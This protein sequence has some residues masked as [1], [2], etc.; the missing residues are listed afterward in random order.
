MFR[1]NV[2]LSLILVTLTVT[3]VDAVSIN[4]RTG[5]ATLSFSTKINGLGDLNIAQKDLARAQ[6]LK[7]G[8]RLAKRSGSNV[9]I[10]NAATNYVAQVGVGSP[11]TD[12]MWTSNHC[13]LGDI[14]LNIERSQTRSSSILGVPTRG[15]VPVRHMSRQEPVSPPGRKSYVFFSPNLVR[16]NSTTT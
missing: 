11:P 6:A 2:L 4:R 5:K 8:R 9:D 16:L 14:E 15:S 1:S 10:T 12:C 7:Q 13:T 3:A